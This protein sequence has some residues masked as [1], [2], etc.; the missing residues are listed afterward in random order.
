MMAF[1]EA[2]LK[3]AGIAAMEGLQTLNEA[4]GVRV[5]AFM[6]VPES[7]SGTKRAAALAGDIMP[8]GAP[9]A[10]NISKMADGL[11][12]HPPRFKGDKEKRPIIWHNDSQIV[13]LHVM[14][15]Y[16]ARPRLV[17]EVFRWF[18]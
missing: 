3:A 9:D 6:P 4:L 11:N 17:V 15:I 8:T 13:S 1:S 14:K 18:G 5:W 7:W 16:D 10:D 2:R 12:H